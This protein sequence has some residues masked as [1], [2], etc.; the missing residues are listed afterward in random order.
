MSSQIGRRRVITGGAATGL[1]IGL[2]NG[3][4]DTS[5]AA[6]RTP[7]PAFNPKPTD[8]DA[9]VFAAA[10]ER[11]LFSP[12][13]TYCNTG[14]LGASPR[15]VMDAFLGG[16]E[17][18]ERELPDWPYF[19]TD[20]EP[21]TGYQKL[22]QARARAGAF[23]NAPMEEVALTQNATMGMNF[24]ANGLE[25][26][27]GDEVITT[28]QEHGGGIGGWQLRAKRYG[29]TVKE[30]PLDSATPGG[31]DAI[32]ELFRKAIGPKTKVIMFSQITSGYGTVLPA[33]ELCALAKEHGI[34][35]VVD[36]AQAVGQIPVDI[37][38]LGCDAFVASPHKWLLA[39]KGT[40]FLYIRRELQEQVW[41]TLGSYA[42]DDHESG[43]FRFM[44]YG[45]GSYP[46]VHG[47]MAALDFVE[48]IGIERIANWNAA[49]STQLRAGLNDIPGA[50]LNSPADP[51]LGAGVTTFSLEGVTGV[52][53]QN[54]L[55]KRKIRVRAQGDSPRV[56]LSAHL[57]V[58]PADID[59]TLEIV[60]DLARKQR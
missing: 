3:L 16:L 41:S 48:K 4:S 60:A 14:T 20:G 45:T 56:R 9:N 34:I 39:P 44:Q 52:D 26:Q 49:Q 29:I 47:L 24:I 31:P 46:V 19:Q 1:A 54:A 43:A 11:F 13:V 35:S 51:R 42:W 2:S 36:G 10:R 21:L 40:G 59:R 57:Y 55:W 12:D 23:V 50:I 7:L 6:T 33:K 32:L 5:R 17:E 58:A 28:D 30:L 18:L 53:L 37:Q 15:D 38:D 22:E 8:P 27:P 25:M